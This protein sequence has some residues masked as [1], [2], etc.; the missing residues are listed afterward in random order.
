MVKIIKMDKIKN[1]PKSEKLER[2]DK[3]KKNDLFV[4]NESQS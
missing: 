4:N 1:N 2:I 3:K